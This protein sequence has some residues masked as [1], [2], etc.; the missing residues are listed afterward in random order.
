MLTP[1]RHQIILQIL[2]QKQTAKI[3]ELADATHSSEST[4]RRDLD[5]LEQKKLLKRVHGGASMIRRTQEE[6][7][8][9]EKNAKN[10]QEKLLIAK[11]AASLTGSGECIFLDAGTTTFQ[12][13]PFLPKGVIVVTNG[14]N[15]IDSLLEHGL[16]TYITG[17]AAKMKTKALIGNAA[18]EGLKKYRFDKA[19]IGVN[20]IHEKFGFTTPDPGEAAIKATA[21]SL[22][23][24]AYILADHTKFQEVTF[25]RIADLEQGTIITNENDQNLLKVYKSKTTI[26]VVTS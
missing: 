23:Q 2:E 1:E 17:G 22:S 20:G 7:S 12:M 26:K 13:I 11:N 5:Q 25:S 6:P 15:L 24:E 19:F 14:L 4:I 16:Q 10:L 9:Q 8:V 3:Q 18:V 21:I